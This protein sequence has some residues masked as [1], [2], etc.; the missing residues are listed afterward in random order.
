MRQF[1]LGSLTAAAMAIGVSTVALAAPLSPQH[2]FGSP[3]SNILNV[4][5]GNS[6]YW[7]HHRYSHRDWDRNHRHWHYYD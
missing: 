1:I 2:N 5:G 3:N 6:Y 7:N 4:Q